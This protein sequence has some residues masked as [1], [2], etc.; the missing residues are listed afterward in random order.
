MPDNVILTGRGRFRVPAV[1][2]DGKSH[3]L[4][5]GRTGKPVLL[6]TTELSAAKAGQRN[7]CWHV[8]RAMSLPEELK[9]VGES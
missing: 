3:V 6:E 8:I 7:S 4:L 1:L 5:D 9:Q 2:L